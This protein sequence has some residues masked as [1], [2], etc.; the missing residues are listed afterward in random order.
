MISRRLALGAG[1]LTLLLA[2][3]QTPAPPRVIPEDGTIDILTLLRSKPEHSRFVNALV[4]S[5]QTSR[6][7][8]ANGAVTLFA[9][10]NEALA[11]LPAPLLAVLDN[12]PA[13]PS[14]EQRAAAAQLVNANAAWNLLR[15]NEIQARRGQVNTWDR[16]RVLVTPTGPRTANVVR[17][18][19]PVQPNRGAVAIT[20]ADVLASDG[21][22]HITNAPI[23]P[24]A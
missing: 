15:L 22:F 14:A 8:R 9:P 19:A 20:R 10:T 1:G 2:A 4:V 18:G 21:I 24:G 23:L 11:G 7:G 6:L 16:G 3:C 13:N 5:G 12:P 17:D